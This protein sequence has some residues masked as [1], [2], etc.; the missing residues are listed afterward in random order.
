MRTATAHIGALYGRATTKLELGKGSGG[1]RSPRAS[2]TPSVGSSAEFE[3]VRPERPRRP[4]R[5]ATIVVA[6]A[7]AAVG[8]GAISGGD[9]EAAS[10][11][12][13]SPQ[14]PSVGAMF[15]APELTETQLANQGLIPHAAVDSKRVELE[16][17][18]NRGLIPPGALVPATTSA[19]SLF[20]PDER[21]SIDLAN[22]GLI[23]RQSVDWNAVE[24]KR[25][26]NRGLIPVEAAR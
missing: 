8:Y 2:S 16:R 9:G 12:E 20:S 25:L 18:V 22:R 17:L 3:S 5:V 11:V 13:S 23:P 21:I 1:G 19:A 14:A 15:T 26:A 7:L 6:A 4:R 10:P 24:L